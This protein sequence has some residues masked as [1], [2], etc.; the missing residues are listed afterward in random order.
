M[1]MRKTAF[2]KQFIGYALRLAVLFAA[3]TASAD[4]AVEVIALRYRSPS[5]I[6]PLVKPL[7]SPEGKISADDRTNQ[8]IVVDRQE[9]IARIR[10]TLSALD[11][12]ASPVTI[13]VRFQEDR[14]QEDRSIAA[15]GR[16]SGRGGSVSA[17]RSRRTGDGLD[18]RWQD[19]STRRAGDSEYFIQVLSG[20]WAYIRVGQDVP[21]SAY[22]M[23]LGRRH[24]QTLAYR[25]IE[26]GFD[27]RPVIRETLVEVEIVP[28]LSEMGSSD[29]SGTVRFAEAATKL[30]VPL[31]QW[32][33]IAGS[34]Q[35][36]SE[37]VRAILETG[38]SRQS[39][40]L[41]LQMMVEAR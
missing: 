13:R 15:G 28:R 29:A 40:A 38:T 24:G 30:L 41:S 8:L 20:N 31:G 37:V 14:E 21:S 9:A 1:N 39:S 11:Q 26:T 5:E 32:I 19:R 3:A 35:T 33:N 22:W 10:Q 17:G 27:V 4:P 18:V 2:L 16:I 36:T 12:P 6:L 23:D 25:R 34:D 7:L